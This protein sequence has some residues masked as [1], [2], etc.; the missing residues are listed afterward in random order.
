MYDVVYADA[1]TYRYRSKTPI[2][3]R[4]GDGIEKNKFCFSAVHRSTTTDLPSMNR[5]HSALLVLVFVVRPKKSLGTVALEH[6][7]Q[8][9]YIHTIL[10]YFFLLNLFSVVRKLLVTRKRDKK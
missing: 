8:N 10:R 4:R 7:S 3:F 1:I 2:Y 9:T 5:L 6:L